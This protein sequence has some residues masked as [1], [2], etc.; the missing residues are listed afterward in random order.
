MRNKKQNKKTHTL[1][2]N[3]N[4][5]WLINYKNKKK[6]KTEK[7]RK[8]QQQQ[9]QQQRAKAKQQ[10]QQNK[11]R[12][13]NHFFKKS[14]T[15]TQTHTHSD[16]HIFFVNKKA[17][18]K[19]K[20]KRSCNSISSSSNSRRRSSS[21]RRQK[22]EKEKQKV[23]VCMYVLFIPSF[24]NNRFHLGNIRNNTLSKQKRERERRKKNKKQ[25]FSL[26]VT[27]NCAYCIGW[28]FL[29]KFLL[30]F[31]CFYILY[32]DERVALIL[33][34]IFF[35]K[36]LFLDFFLSFRFFCETTKSHSA[37]LANMAATWVVLF[38]LGFAIVCKETRG[39]SRHHAG[40]FVCFSRHRGFRL[41][42]RLNSF[43][44]FCAKVSR[45]L[46][47][48]TRKEGEMCFTQNIRSRITRKKINTELYYSMPLCHP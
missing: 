26:F 18:N 35:R 7:E 42:F 16:R 43:D 9:Q 11:C 24:P 36:L 33:L 28:R 31:F 17:A 34:V 21:K 37:R 13:Q 10:Q 15:V 14:L 8:Q 22:R 4:S 46:L 40:S 5:F 20:T 29:R 25:K 41:G 12:K 2:Y 38:V 45:L 48:Q 39:G 1:K 30:L 27:N 6:N 23:H 3:R 32:D 44:F 47:A 19:T